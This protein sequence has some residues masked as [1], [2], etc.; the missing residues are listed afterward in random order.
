MPLGREIVELFEAI[1]DRIEVSGTGP[2]WRV[3]GGSFDSVVS[4]A[5]DAFDDPVV[6]AREDR[7]R[8]WPRVTLTV[9]TDPELAGQAP[10][11][12]AFIPPDLPEPEPE[13]GPEPKPEPQPTRDI[14]P[15]PEPV[16]DPLE[17]APPELTDEEGFSPLEEIFA[18]QEEARVARRFPEQRAR[19]GETH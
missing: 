9:T 3:T 8:W 7:S 19:G 14:E 2:T 11:L 10:P 13:P 5:N 12:E 17:P 16:P 4:W 18:S 6:I 15:A 1:P